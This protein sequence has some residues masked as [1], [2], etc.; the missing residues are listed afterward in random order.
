MFAEPERMDRHEGIEG[1]LSLFSCLPGP[2]CRRHIINKFG[3]RTW[4]EARTRIQQSIK[5]VQAFPLKGRSRPER[6]DFQFT[7]YYQV[8]SGM[9]RIIRQVA[10]DTICI[11]VMSDTRGPVKAKLE[12]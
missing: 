12:K 11:H 4:H 10:N 7:G 1:S 6:M 2:A 5:K 8:S 3:N 9:N